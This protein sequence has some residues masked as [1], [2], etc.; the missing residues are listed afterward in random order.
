MFRQADCGTSWVH[1]REFRRNAAAYLRVA[2]I[3]MLISMPTGTSTIFGA[4]QAIRFSICSRGEC[5]PRVKVLRIGKFASRIFLTGTRGMLML[6]RKRFHGDVRAAVV[7]TTW[8][9]RF[10]GCSYRRECQF[11]VRRSAAAPDKELVR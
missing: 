2:H 11:W 10:R 6:H 7:K 8:E 3:Y 9:Q 1:L 5:R 4:F